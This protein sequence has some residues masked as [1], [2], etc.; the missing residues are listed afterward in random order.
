MDPGANTIASCYLT[1]NFI[2]T[3]ITTY[4]TIMCNSNTP[5]II[6]GF[7]LSLPWRVAPVTL[8]PDPAGEFASQIYRF[9]EH[10]ATQFDR[11][12]MIQQSGTLR[13]GQPI[14]G[15]LMGRHDDP[16]EDNLDQGAIVHADFYITDQFE[17]TYTYDLSL[18]VDRTAER[19]SKPRPAVQRPRLFDQPDFQHQK[20][21]F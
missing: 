21:G 1:R 10:D 2:G 14:R 18:L 17:K 4:L 6:S 11:S 5:L 16:L 8:L 3:V 13:S 19:G 9:S 15:F 20:S 12:Q 7:G